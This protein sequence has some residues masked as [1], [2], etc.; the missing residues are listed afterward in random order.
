M[1][2]LLL[3][4]T[5]KQMPDVFVSQNKQKQIIDDQKHALASD[6]TQ[7]G[8]DIDMAPLLIEITFIQLQ[9]MHVLDF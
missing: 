4:E 9:G 2:L 8:N 1:L 3:L 7:T 5:K 6:Q